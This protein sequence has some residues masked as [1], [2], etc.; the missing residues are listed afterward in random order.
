MPR[1]SRVEQREVTP[2][3]RFQSQLVSKFINR[4]MQR[5][6]KTTAMAIVYGALDLIA[7]RHKQN[8]LEVFNQAMR[9]AT[10]VLEV[11]PRRVGGATY[12]IP[13]EIEGPRRESLAIRWIVQAAQAR[14]G[15]SM[16]EKLAAELWD[17]FQNTGAAIKKR[18]ETH[19][20]AEANKAFAHYRW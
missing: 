12:Q 20:M 6:K 17:A 15:K 2:D 1:R 18:D 5:G 11:R 9:N 14:P 4:L 13:L 10:P 8:P 3:P 16:P 7:E 19:R